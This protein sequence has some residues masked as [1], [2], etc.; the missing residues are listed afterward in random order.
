MLPNN[1]LNEERDR[2][3]YRWSHQLFAK[4]SPA[5][6]S[7]ADDTKRFEKS[8][9]RSVSA[10]LSSALANPVKRI[11]SA[12]ENLVPSVEDPTIIPRNRTLRLRLL[13]AETMIELICT[14]MAVRA[15]ESP[16]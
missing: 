12:L 9:K 11:S 6:G 15:P 16:T 7:S 14:V 8:S 10:D 3:L 5:A 4:P 13:H 1:L 2:F